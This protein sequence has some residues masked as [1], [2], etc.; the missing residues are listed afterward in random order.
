MLSLQISFS[1]LSTT[2]YTLS[3]QVP[4]AAN[5]LLRPNPVFLV[6]IVGAALMRSLRLIHFLRI[7]TWNPHLRI[8]ARS[9]LHFTF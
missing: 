2:N 8:L 1:R 4:M 6:L 3:L 7:A 9:S 5:T